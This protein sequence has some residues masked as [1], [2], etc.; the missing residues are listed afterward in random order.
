MKIAGTDGIRSNA[1]RRKG[2]TIEGAEGNFADHMRT[3]DRQSA[4]AVPGSAQIASVEALIALQAGGS[5]G[6]DT[7]RRE[8]DR[9]DALLDQLDRIRVGIL[10]GALSRET[11]TGIV[12]RLGERR[13]EGIEP[14]L[15]GLIDEIELRAR[16]EL[17]KLSAVTGVS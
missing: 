17:A 5:V 6:S 4:A 2:G 13:R 3:R 15:A 12:A 16:V 14:R 9:A 8:I 11:L 7:A 10:T 1:A